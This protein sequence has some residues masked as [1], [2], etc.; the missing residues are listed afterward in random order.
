MKAIIAILLVLASPAGA[1]DWT[2]LRDNAAIEAALTGERLIYDA[3]T[4]QHFGADGATQYVTERLSEGRW[5]AR[6]GQYCS[7]WPPSDVWACYD[8]QARGDAVRFIG[9]DRSI[10]EGRFDK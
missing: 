7:V 6:G 1:Q 4:F 8:V 9:A 10:S 2:P 5:A 3:Y